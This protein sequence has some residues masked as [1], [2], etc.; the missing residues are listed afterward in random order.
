[1]KNL[2][3]VDVYTNRDALRVAFPA[4][5]EI[6]QACKG[7]GTTSRHIECDGGGFTASEW[8][9]QDEEF[10]QDYMDG[11][12]DRE[13]CDCNGLGRVQTI[14]VDAIRGWRQKLLLRAYWEQEKDSRDIDAMMAAERRMGA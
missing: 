13:C 8:A 12:Y 7:N 9:E 14:D 11:L 6:C 1:M 5:W 4:K 2:I 10:R 3:T